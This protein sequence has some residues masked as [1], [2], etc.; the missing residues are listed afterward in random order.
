MKLTLACLLAILC[1]GFASA[2]DLTGHWP[3]QA[4]MTAPDGTQH[5]IA[6]YLD[7]KQ[8]GTTVTG[9][10]GTEQ[11]ESLPLEDVSFDGKT[12]SFK[13]SGPDGRT[14]KSALT[15]ISADQLEGKL[16]FTIEDGTAITAKMTLKRAAAK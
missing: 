6:A 9:S 13:V 1:V 11:G 15:L 10:G 8:E 16:E 2:A 12:L 14:Y 5:S 4:E 3:G 7:L